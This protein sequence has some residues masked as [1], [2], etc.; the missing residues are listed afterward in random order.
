VETWQEKLDQLKKSGLSLLVEKNSTVVYTSHE[1]MLKPLYLCLKE[2]PG[3]L[4][5]STV[6][7]KVV[8]RAAAL[9]CAHAGVGEIITPLISQSAITV[10]EQYKIT[11]H[12]SRI[13][14]Q[15]MNRDRSGPCPMEHLASQFDSPETFFN[16]LDQRIK[17]KQ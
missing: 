1:P 15:I 11:Y 6:I 2:Q 3:D 13:I 14:P 9:L 10:L 5:G 12:A 17:V 16:E 8:G 4:A 7:D